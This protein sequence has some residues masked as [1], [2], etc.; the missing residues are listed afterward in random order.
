MPFVIEQALDID[1]PAAVVWEV[2]TDFAKYPDWNPFVV[3]A[4]S[5][6]Q[7]G[8]AIEMRVQLVAKP[9]FQREWI[10]EVQP[11][12][13]FSYSMKPMPLGALRSFR[14]HAIEAQAKER[15]RYVSHFEMQGWMEPVVLGLF[16][17][18]LTQGFEG[19]TQGVKTRAEALW[20]QRRGRSA[21]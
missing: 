13:G 19:M 5:T 20:Q 12:Q 4:K 6:L 15:S 11:G 3:E 10:R 16:R 21:A 1:A 9:Q 17:K 8:A 2:L 7:P 18:G 14:S